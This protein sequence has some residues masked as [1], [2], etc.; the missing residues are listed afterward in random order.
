MTTQIAVLGAAGRM[1]RRII[2]LSQETEGAFSL[3]RAI[4]HSASPALGSD[5]GEVAQ[6]SRL[7][8]P[9][10]SELSFAPEHVIIDFTQPAILESVVQ[11]ALDAQCSLVCGT[12]GL[13]EEHKAL[14]EKAAQSIPVLY[15]PNMSV[16]VNL[17]F[18]VARQMAK[19]IPELYDI[20]VL[21]LHHKHKKDAPSGTAIRL[22]EMLAEGREKV[23]KDVVCMSREGR[24]L[25]RKPDEIGIQ[26][27]RGGDIAGEHTAF[28]CGPG[29]RLELTHR[30]TSRDIFA[31]GALKAAAWLNGQQPGLYSMFDVLA[32]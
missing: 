20:E 8:V 24:D 1:G 30:A 4:E 31:R 2:A 28:F 9:I 16:G 19:M 5:A 7:D 10:T 32:I 22:A 25:E 27:I 26:S 18:L 13:E 11:A 21:E 14:L 3:Q 12:T 17:M 29:E 23:L 15:S 6:A